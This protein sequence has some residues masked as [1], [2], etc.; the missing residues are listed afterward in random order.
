MTNV[1]IDDVARLAGVSAKTVS[2]VANDQPNVTEHTRRKVREAIAH[3]NYEPNPYARYLGSLPPRNRS[4]R[5]AAA[6]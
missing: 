4:T 6:K 2:R 1:T 5:S 3:L